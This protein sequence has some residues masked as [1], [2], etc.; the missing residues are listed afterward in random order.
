MLIVTV[1]IPHASLGASLVLFY[2]YI[3][4]LKENGYEILHLILLQPNYDRE[5]LARYTREMS[6]KASFKI[7]THEAKRHY[8]I[9]R[10][11]PKICI[12]PLPADVVLKINKFQPD[13]VLCFDILSASVVDISVQNLKAKKIVW[14]GDLNFQ[15][16]WFHAVYGLKESFS[17][18][19]H[20][21]P[22]LVLSFLWERFYKVL[23]PKWDEVIVA[24]KSSERE[25]Q[26]RGIRGTYLPYPWPAKIKNSA[27]TPSTPAARPGW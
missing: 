6:D 8:V 20:C 7:I 23:L 13:T 3:W 11:T 16:Y 18:I 25:L 15:T 1:G 9:R 21:A 4:R 17:N 27:G 26:K 5:A 24:S 14:L 22:A 10:L 12:A 2:H 19:F